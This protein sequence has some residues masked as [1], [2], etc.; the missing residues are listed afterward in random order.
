[1]RLFDGAK[2]SPMLGLTL[3]EF[4]AMKSEAAK[5]I[6]ISG[7]QPK[8]SLKRNGNLLE[9][10]DHGGEYI[11]KPVAQG[12]FDH[13][14]AMP[15]NEHVT[16]QLARQVF[17]I[18]TAECAL[19]TL[20]DGETPCYLTRRFDVLPDGSRQLQEDFAQVAQVSE[21]SHGK[22]YKYDFSYERIGTLM[23][24]FVGAYAVEVEKL[25][26][27]V[28]FNYLIHNGDAHVKNF[29]LFRDQGTGMTRL[30]PAY[31]LLNTRLHL[32]NESAMALDLF[33]NDFTTASY[34]SLGFHAYD[35]FYEF[36]VRLGIAPQR[37]T[38]HLAEMV[39]HETAIL[40]LL[41]NSFLSS[42]LV[43]RYKEMVKDRHRALTTKA[44]G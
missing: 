22:N 31:D 27:H 1:M 41:D 34:D 16:M 12:V 17:K 7:V 28:I 35:D 18:P 2:V 44:V 23:K 30:T 13:M 40:A 32:P 43:G 15:A 14:E 25:F 21:P 39:S 5:R 42:A 4:T 6:S 36:G 20:S 33:D 37:I 19:L 26:R 3:P 24:D 29:S 38:R 11:L 10:T 9:L 8:Y